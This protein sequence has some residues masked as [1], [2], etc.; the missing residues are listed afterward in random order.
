MPIGCTGEGLRHGTGERIG[1]QL[2]GAWPIME[3]VER[4]GLG[5]S[6]LAVSVLAVSVLTVSALGPTTREAPDA[7]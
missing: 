2:A 1:P 5:S 6:G 3:A 7:I 4:R